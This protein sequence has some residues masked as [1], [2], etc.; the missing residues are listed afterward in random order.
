MLLLGALKVLLS[1]L[2]YIDKKQLGFF[3]EAALI[4]DKI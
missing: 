1:R 2:E 3:S 4:L